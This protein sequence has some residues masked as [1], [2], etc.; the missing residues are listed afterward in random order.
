M[1]NVSF[2]DNSGFVFKY[3]EEIYRQIN[4][5][6][7]DDYEQFMN[8]GLY[9]ELVSKHMIV[10]HKEV[11]TEITGNGNG[12]KIIK[13]EQIKFITYPYEWC[14][15]ELKDA[16]LLTL[17]IQKIALKHD[18]SLKDA[19]AFNIQFKNGKPIFIDTLSFEKYKENAP[20]IAY[21]QFCRHFLAPLVL[22]SYKDV[23]LNKLLVTNIDGIPLELCCKLLPLRAKFNP[24]NFVHIVLHA[25]SIKKNENQSHNSNMN[26][27]NE[28][29]N[30]ENLNPKFSKLA[31]SGLIDSLEDCIKNLKLPELKTEWGE[32]YT[33][34]NYTPD[35]FYQKEEIV[36]EFIQTITPETICDL[37]ANRGDFSRTAINA[38]DKTFC[39]S[40]DIDPAAVELNYNLIKKNG[41]D[42]I[43]PLILDLT[44]PT[45]AIGFANKERADFSSRFKCDAV[46]ALALIHHLAI[47]NNLPF[48]NIASF[49]AKL[50]EYLIIE[51]VPKDDSKVQILL[52]T[53][54]DIFSN[55]TEE[56]F[57]KVFSKTYTILAKKQIRNSK[58]IIY[59]MRRK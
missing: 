4:T 6:Y 38:C 36:K 15:S 55:Y 17:E 2:R 26:R 50:G 1:N 12:Y 51:F 53:R 59:L 29:S 45:P 20:W 13:P 23:S 27:G 43:L 5:V 35:A 31:M 34:T 19:S 33:N 11:D 41:E 58:R 25:I 32:Y 22:M 47:S 30:Q 49:F 40:F 37:G 44:N 54:K 48:E 8:S 24:A 18:M 42:R 14:F 57:E 16:A 10:S 56:F 21:G 28:R 3:N 52:S 7:K 9:D 46:L 39:L